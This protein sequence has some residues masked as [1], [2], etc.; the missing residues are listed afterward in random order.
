MLLANNGAKLVPNLKEFQALDDEMKKLS[1][2]VWSKK[3]DVKRAKVI[4]QAAARRLTLS[5]HMLDIFKFCKVDE[6]PK[7]ALPAP[8]NGKK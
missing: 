8:K 3:L 1:A 7:L 2:G 6:Q 5:R 4:D